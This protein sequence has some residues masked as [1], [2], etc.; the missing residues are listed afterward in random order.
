MEQVRVFFRKKGNLRY[1]SHLDLQRA[2]SRALQRSG[3]DIVYSEGYNPHPKI[4]F[5]LPLSVYIES[6]YE[7]MDFALYKDEAEDEIIKRLISVMP[8]GLN[9]YKIAEPKAKISSC[10]KAKYRFE[11]ITKKSLE[12]IQDAL[13]GSIVINKRSKS[14][15][16]LTD[17]THLITEK[18][19]FDREGDIVLEAT[20]AAG[21]ADYLSPNYIVSFLGESID[22]C[23][24]TRL[25]LYGKDGN[26]LE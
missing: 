2:M 25:R 26:L 23:R 18:V 21:G 10:R 9:I 24:I 5:A 17:V 15:E 1:I 16:R 11:F 6:E 19:F 7:I 3:L 14:G 20:L 22:D 13:S 12:E 4:A 8:E